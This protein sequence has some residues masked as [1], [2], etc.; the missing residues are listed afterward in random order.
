MKIPATWIIACG[1]IAGGAQAVAAESAATAPPAKAHPQIGSH[2][3]FQYYKDM[4]AA[5]RFYGETMGLK[6]T[7]DQKWVKMFQITPHSYVGL[8]EDGKGYYPAP[9]ATPAV[10]LSIES[11]DLEGWYQRL[12]QG[13]AN[14]LKELGTPSGNSDTPV[15][16]ILFKD[17][18]G[19]TVEVFRWKAPPKA[20]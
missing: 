12:K 17:P 5:E 1:L 16:S 19:Y 20:Q 3:V 7:F 9:A 10:M 4:A 14:F 13:K 6:K 11:T 15:N 2:V 18:G 8:V